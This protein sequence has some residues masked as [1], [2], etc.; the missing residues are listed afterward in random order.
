MRRFFNSVSLIKNQSGFPALLLANFVLGSA[1]SQ[2]VP[3]MSMFGTLEVGMSPM[4]FGI[5]MVV[6]TLSGIV[7]NTVLAKWSD[8]HITRRTM[9]LIGGSGGLLGYLGYAMVRDPIWLTVIGMTVLALSQVCFSQVFAHA[10]EEL[11]ADDQSAVHA[12]LLMS[13]LRM[14]FSLAWTVGPAIGAVIMIAFGY[15]GI[16]IAAT[17]MFG[18]FLGLVFRF[19]PDRPHPPIGT[20]PAQLPLLKALTRPDILWHY[21]AF[22]LIFAAHS[23]SMMNLPLMV[24][25]LL[26]GNEGHVGIIFGIAPVVEI[27]LFIWFGQIAARGREVLMIRLGAVFVVLYYG[28][29]MFVQA[30]WH[31]YPLQ[32][33]S[34]AS[35]AVTTGVAITFF[36]DFLPGQ[37]GTATSIYANSFSG[38]SLVGYF[39]FGLLLPALGHRGIYGICFALVIVTLGI[40]FFAQRFR[41]ATAVIPT[42]EPS[43]QPA[44]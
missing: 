30:P 21:V 8:T 33:L 7:V 2:V 35:I 44:P 16:F 31:I 38:G 6:T 17:V 5:F 20:K 15:R 22:V 11:A 3:F 4:V 10:R 1:Y 29:L 37:T 32:I 34:A 9:L 13:V 36:Q 27:P 28:A 14:F 40:L 25:Q 19:V 39:S 12:P 26:G 18:L 24:T 43:V 42:N 23:M 41:V